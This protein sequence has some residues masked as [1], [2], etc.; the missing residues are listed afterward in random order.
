MEMFCEDERNKVALSLADVHQRI[1]LQPP[2]LNWA[3][4]GGQWTGYTT[5]Y[6]GPEGSG[7]SLLSHMGAAAAQQMDPEAIATIITTE[8]RPPNI[9]KLAALGVDP[10]RLMIRQCNTIHDVFDWIASKESKF[11]NSDGKKGGPGLAY[12]LAQG[13][14]VNYLVID[15]IKGLRGPKELGSKSSEDHIMGDISFFL[16]P[17]L[18]KILDVIR[19]NNICTTFVQQVNM[20]MDTNEV[21]YQNIKYTIPSGQALKHFCETMCLVERLNTKAHKLLNDEMKLIRDIPMTEGHTIRVKVQKANLDYPF[22]EAEFRINYNKGIVDTGLEVAKLGVGLGVIQHPISPK[23]QKEITS[24]WFAPAVFGKD[25]KWI[26]FDNFVSEL[27]ASPET[28]RQLM[29]HIYSLDNP[30][31]IEHADRGDLVEAPAET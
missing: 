18:R 25:K 5:C 16:N 14:P 31:Q 11:T 8:R 2:S 12:M 27:D 29:G 26:G 22:R 10:K 13:A 28:Q 23:T 4:G 9:K 15:S 3:L 19:D 21:K 7:K 30:V 1:F 17:A 20:N 24:Q 6:Y